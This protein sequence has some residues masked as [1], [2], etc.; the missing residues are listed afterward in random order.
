MLCNILVGL[1]QFLK[2]LLNGMV[3]SFYNGWRQKAL[4]FE[5]SEFKIIVGSLEDLLNNF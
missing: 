2:I 1:L 5:R 3:Y 4:R